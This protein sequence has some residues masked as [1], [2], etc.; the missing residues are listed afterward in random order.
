[1]SEFAQAVLS[2]V[3]PQ[4]Q[5]SH[6]QPWQALLGHLRPVLATLMV[7]AKDDAALMQSIQHFM[8]S[9]IEAGCQPIDQAL[10]WERYD[11]EWLEQL[12]SEF[13]Q[14]DVPFSPEVSDALQS[15]LQPLDEESALAEWRGLGLLRS[16]LQSEDGDAPSLMASDDP[17]LAVAQEMVCESL[18][19]MEQQ[20]DGMLPALAALPEAS[21]SM[22]LLQLK[23]GFEPTLALLQPEIAKLSAADQQ[24]AQARIHTIYQRLE[25]AVDA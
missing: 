24:Q 3:Q 22:T 13:S 16:M 1:M 6:D 17:M 14:A 15:C 2:W 7:L 5:L 20:L 18:L 9:G 23:A 8:V 19:A 11:Q 4:D 10:A 21:R 25:P 12:L